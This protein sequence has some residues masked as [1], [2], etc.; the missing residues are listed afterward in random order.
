MSEYLKLALLIQETGQ[1][2]DIVQFVSNFSFF[3]LPF[4][5]WGQIY[6]FFTE[7][8]VFGWIVVVGLALLFLFILPSLYDRWRL[9]RYA[10]KLMKRIELTRCKL[11]H[12]TR[13]E[14]K[15]KFEGEFDRL[16]VSLVY[17]DYLPFLA[18]IKQSKRA[19]L[20]IIVTLIFGVW[21]SY[22]V[23]TMLAISKDSILSILS[24]CPVQVIQFFNFLIPQYLPV[25]IIL[26]FCLSLPRLYP[27]YKIYSYHSKKWLFSIVIFTV[28]VTLI[29]QISWLCESI[30]VGLHRLRRR[31]FTLNKIIPFIKTLDIAAIAE[32]SV[33]NIEGSSCE[34]FQRTY[35]VADAEDIQNIIN[36]I[37]DDVD[38]PSTYKYLIQSVKPSDVLDTI[39]ILQP[40]FYVCI[41]RSK[42][43]ALGGARYVPYEKVYH[44]FFVFDSKYVKEEFE[45]IMSKEIEKQ[46]DAC[47]HAKWANAK[48]HL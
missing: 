18:F 15:G 39:K 38:I 21:F 37:K 12:Q 23:V 1:K 35:E 34:F 20:I 30:L 40:V 26:F 5:F 29:L 33:Q 46:R 8:F 10:Q 6:W 17:S 9:F 47:M 19:L 24:F 42:C 13:T 41:I 7:K 16:G 22:A 14:E 43:V 48:Q 4:L 2:I 45:A 36:V 44:G 27:N 31:R 25:L 32:K 3:I 28:S 11:N